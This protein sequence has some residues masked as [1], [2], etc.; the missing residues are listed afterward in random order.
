MDKKKPKKKTA[1]NSESHS[2]RNSKKTSKISNDDEE[3]DPS[4]NDKEVGCRYSYDFW[5]K[6]FVLYE[7]RICRVHD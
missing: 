6:R 7:F 5:R 4:K 3:K 2:K 1:Q